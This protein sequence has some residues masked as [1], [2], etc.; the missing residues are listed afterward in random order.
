M[1]P[2]KWIKTK[3]YYWILI[4]AL[5]QIINKKINGSDSITNIVQSIN[6]K[7]WNHGRYWTNSHQ[8]RAQ[9]YLDEAFLHWLRDKIIMNNYF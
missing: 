7:I 5:N 8:K 1:I 6:R 2:V 3:K 9:K 4:M